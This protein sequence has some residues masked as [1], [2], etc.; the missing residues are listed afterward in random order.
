MINHKKFL[1]S[2]VLVFAMQ[3][4]AAVANTTGP[5]AVSPPADAPQDITP[6]PVP[7]DLIVNHAGLD[8]VWASPC[9]QG[10]CSNPDPNNQE[11]WR[12]ATQE[13]LQNAPTCEA[14][15][16]GAKC[17]SQYFDPIYSH[18]D[19]VNCQA[20]QIGSAPGEPCINGVY[21][22]FCE[23][24]YVRGE[25]EEGAATARFQVTKTFSDDS[26]DEVEV[27]LTCNTGLPLTQSFTIA[28]GD[29]TGVTF[30]VEEIAPGATNC[31]VTETGSP[32]G[33]EVVMNGGDGCA[34]EGLSSGYYICEIDNQALPG[35]FTVYK[36]WV[37]PNS[38]GETVDEDVSVTIT[39]DSEILDDDA[40]NPDEDIWTLSGMIGDGES[41]TAS[42]DTSEGPA[43]CSATENVIQSG[44]ESSDD[45]GARAIAAGGSDSCTFTN[46]VF[47]EGIPTMNQYGL[48]LLALL[49]LGVGAVSF[50]RFV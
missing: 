24:F 26:T 44:V 45:C 39:C 27:T 42:V 1:A 20:N 46:T 34:W 19:L 36:D 29:E 28:G 38:G 4:L 49:M 23:S 37:I 33:Y 30:V 9:I 50:R 32:G 48:A 3:P 5:G 40:N 31:E 41:L 7:D 10:G 35:T 43:N 21:S 16:N 6:G 25:L 14:F 17:A 8:W 18:C 12:F 2:L 47:F 22:G 15:D 11:G 13:E